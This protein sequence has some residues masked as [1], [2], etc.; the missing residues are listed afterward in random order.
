MLRAVGWL[1]SAWNTLSRRALHTEDGLIL[2][3]E[4]GVPLVV[5][6]KNEVFGDGRG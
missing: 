4:D 2:T 5:E 3:T 1:R 6:D